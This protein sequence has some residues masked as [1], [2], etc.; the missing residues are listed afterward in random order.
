MIKLI[1]DGLSIENDKVVYNADADSPNDVMN[2]IE[3][4]IYKSEFGGNVYYF[5]YS[6][7]KSASRKDRT[8]IIRWIKGLGQDVADSA[9]VKNMIDKALLYFNKNVNISDISCI[10]Y[11]RS[12]RSSLTNTIIKELG[13]F[14]QRDTIKTAIEFV[15]SLPKDVSFDWEEFDFE[16]DG[17]IGDNQ[18]NQIKDYIESTLL[19]SIHSLDYFSLADS[20]K[21]K[22]RRYI[23]NY[24]NIDE[25]SKEV[26]KSIQSGKILIVDD[27]NTSGSTLN[28]IIRIIRKINNQCEIYIFTLIGKE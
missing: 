13:D 20:V 11:P 26:I 14:S 27:I 18:Y 22:Y 7:K 5:G 1:Y 15:K 8:T 17:V 9:S 10:V 2:V 16:Y 25:R 21:V 4:D 6:F 12:G 28:E 19:P 23:K 24:L 3:P